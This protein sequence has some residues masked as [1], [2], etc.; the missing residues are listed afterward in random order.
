MGTALA[1][2][3]LQDG[4]FCRLGAITGSLPFRITTSG[5][6]K[7]STPGKKT[8]E[9]RPSRIR[10]DPVHVKEEQRLDKVHW[11]SSEK[12]IWLAVLGMVAFALAINAVVI[13]ISAHLV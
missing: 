11:R 9:L 6:S 3:P 10:R 2:P 5:V 12:E 8:V 1:A 4:I 7:P 13:G